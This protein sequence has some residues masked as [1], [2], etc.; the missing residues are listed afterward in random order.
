M[1]VWRPA[2]VAAIFVL[3]SA[4]AALAEDGA[5]P[6]FRVFL[7]DGASL[8]SYGE[9]VRMGDKVVFS[10]PLA[11]GEA[12]DLQLVSLPASR[13][14]WARTERY[15]DTVRTVHY[16][17]TR[18]E[19]DFARFSNQVAEV[20]SGVAREPDAKRRLAMAESARTALAE[21]PRQHYGYRAADVQQM[22]S[23]LDEVISDLRGAAG[24]DQFQVNLVAATPSP[25]AETLLPPPTTPELAQELLTASTLAESPTER[26]TL[27]DRLVSFLDRAA[28]LL[29][30]AWATRVRTAAIGTLSSERATDAAYRKLAA[31]TLDK[32]SA[33]TR[34]VDVRG[35][36]RLRTETLKAD[37]K[38]GGRRPAE[39][40]AVLAAIDAGAESARRLRLAR[41]QWKLLEPAYRSYQRSVRPALNAL[42]AATD[43]LEDIRAQAGPSPRDLKRVMTRFY[44]ARPAVAST[45]PPEPL[46]AAHA[47]LQSAW[48]LADNALKLRLRAVETGS[49]GRSAE[50]SAAAAGA[51]MLAQRARDD[52]AQAVKMPALP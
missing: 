51:L 28:D 1:Q 41:D 5:T 31:S 24:Q 36:E 35:L 37:Q 7:S 50:A 47:L 21:W 32:V 22:L 6:L 33:R 45:N 29:P 20:L 44:K 16:A 30:S 25:P 12:P 18:A 11:S 10:L 46:A 23:L 26:A 13:V 49:P 40:A 17:S 4:A 9:W 38:L 27:L 42:A 34:A 15:A 8:T 2:A 39:V 43:P 14:D 3:T 19:D 52:I 48:D